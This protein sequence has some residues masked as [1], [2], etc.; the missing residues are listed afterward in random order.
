[1]KKWPKTPLDKPVKLDW[2]LSIAKFRP[3]EQI[4]ERFTLTR[5]VYQVFSDKNLNSEKSD[6]G[7]MVKF[8]LREMMLDPDKLQSKLKQ[9]R[10]VGVSFI[11]NKK[12]IKY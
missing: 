1:M 6:K 3:G 9:L 5:Y 12:S 11:K 8:G 10:I 4:K 7:H 2:S